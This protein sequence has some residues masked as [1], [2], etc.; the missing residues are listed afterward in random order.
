[1]RR[2]MIQSHPQFSMVK[3]DSFCWMEL[4]SISKGV[5]LEM[6]GIDRY[7]PKYNL[8]PSPTNCTTYLSSPYVL[9]G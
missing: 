1:M 9:S 5:I 4:E 2:D 8:S 3:D 7:V 6:K